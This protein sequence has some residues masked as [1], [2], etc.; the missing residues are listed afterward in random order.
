M[1][2]LIKILMVVIMMITLTACS[3][4]KN[5]SAEDL[6][7]KL[8]NM[9]F[10]TKD[11]TS[12]MEDSNIKKVI[13]ANNNKIQIE[14]YVFK[15]EDSA[16]TAYSTNLKSLKENK[17]FKVKEKNNNNYNKSTQATKNLYN[18]IIRNG[19]TMIYSSV[20]VNY[21]SDV[22]KVIKKLGY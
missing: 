12:E 6:E 19:D 20:N 8:S 15:S 3:Q 18:V 9:D 7:K 22:N 14:Y 5:I 11:V 17:D 1:K 2:K 4:K 10:V 16:K 13:L 21:K